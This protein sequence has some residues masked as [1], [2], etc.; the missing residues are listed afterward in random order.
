[1]IDSPQYSFEVKHYLVKAHSH[2][3]SFV[4]QMPTHGVKNSL[5]V[6]FTAMSTWPSQLCWS[7]SHHG[8]FVAQVPTHG[9]KNSLNVATC[10]SVLIWEALR[11][12]D[13]TEGKR[14]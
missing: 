2:H 11:Q 7:Y 5:N 12:W 14:E 10:A 1:M 3:S 13:D 4:A 6:A 9:V 8:S